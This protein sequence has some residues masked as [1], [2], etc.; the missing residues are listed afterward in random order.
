MSPEL[1]CSAT[2]AKTKFWLQM[3]GY[4]LGEIIPELQNNCERLQATR[5]KR[6]IINSESSNTLLI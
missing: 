2:Y 3:L 5:P 1:F 4:S 6:F